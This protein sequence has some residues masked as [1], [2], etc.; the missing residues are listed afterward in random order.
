MKKLSKFLLSPVKHIIGL[1]YGSCKCCGFHW[2][3][4]EPHS[5]NVADG[6]GC[7]AT[8]E[9]CWKNKSDE[10]IISAYNKM[11]DSWLL[12]DSHN[13]SLT[14]E[15]IGFTREQMLSALKKELLQKKY[16]IMTKEEKQLLIKDLSARLPYGVKVGFKDSDLI[17]KPKQYDII[18]GQLFAR[19]IYPESSLSTTYGYFIHD[20]RPYLRPMSYMTE[21]ECKEFGDL[22]TTIEN[23]GETLPNVPYYI[24]VVRPEQLDW[25]NSH[26]FDYRGLIE[27][28]LA[29]EAPEDMYKTE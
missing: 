26:H 25:L 18:T 6:V 17:L 16:K 15:Q 19:Q 2:N 4:V 21:E 3:M 13:E 9:D 12:G 27:K 28:G 10:E 22:P 24:E 11:Y 1:G 5:I 20:Y 29:L 14:T 7:F 8:C 23:V